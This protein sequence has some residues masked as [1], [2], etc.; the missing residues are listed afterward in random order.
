MNFLL[1]LIPGKDVL[2]YKRGPGWGANQNLEPRTISEPPAIVP[3]T[4]SPVF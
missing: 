3:K 2:I 4:G 1:Y